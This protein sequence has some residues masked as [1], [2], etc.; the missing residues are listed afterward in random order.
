MTFNNRV[1]KMK[2]QKYTKRGLCLIICTQLLSLP[3]EGDNIDVQA[4]LTHLT[5]F[6]AVQTWFHI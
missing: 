6:R 3:Q 1:Q 5:Y 2:K 4:L